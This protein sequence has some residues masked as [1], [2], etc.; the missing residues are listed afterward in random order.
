MAGRSCG[1]KVTWQEGHVAGRSRGRVRSRG[2]CVTSEVGHVAVVAGRYVTSQ[3]VG[4][5]VGYRNGPTVPGYF[6]SFSS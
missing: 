4:C 2:R 1:K 6:N 5:M 3:V